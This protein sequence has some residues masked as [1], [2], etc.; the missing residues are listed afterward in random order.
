MFVMNDDL[1]IYATRGDI[2]F[3]NV[4]AMD[5]NMSYKFQPGEIVRMSIYGKKEA[6]ECVMQKDFAVE[7]V[8][9]NVFI[10]LDEE[11]T[12][13]GE[14]ISKHKDYWYEIVLNP[15]TMPQT[16]IGYDE[17]GAKIFR[18]FPESA[19]I[20][21]TYQPSVED[22]PVVDSELDMTSPRP[23]A[24]QAIARA[25][26]TIL[27]TCERTNAAVA[28]N[29][30]TPEMFGAI[31]DG[32]ADDTEAIQA[33]LDSGARTVLL[34]KSYRIS[35]SLKI[36]SNTTVMFSGA[37]HCYQKADGGYYSA[38]VLEDVENVSLDNPRLVCSYEIEYEWSHGI[39]LNRTRN[40]SMYN[41]HCAGFADGVCVSYSISSESYNDNLYIDSIIADKCKRNGVT[42]ECCKDS[43]IGRI[44]GIEVGGFS[45]NTCL[46]IEHDK[47]GLSIENLVIDSVY[48]YKCNGGVQ[49]IL[50]GY[51]NINVNNVEIL[52]GNFYFTGSES[53]VTIDSMR[54]IYSDTIR[55]FQIMDNGAVAIK[56]K[57]SIRHLALEGNGISNDVHLVYV[58]CNSNTFIDVESVKIDGI[59]SKYLY[60][61]DDYTDTADYERHCRLF[62]VDGFGNKVAKRAS[63]KWLN[64]FSSKFEDE[65][66]SYSPVLLLNSELPKLRNTW[67]GAETV[68]EIANGGKIIIPDCS[69]FKPA[70]VLNTVGDRIR[71]VFANNTE[72]SRAFWNV[73]D[74]FLLSST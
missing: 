71:I 3:F 17:N 69:N 14:S 40:V 55:D 54:C 62:G 42:V 59:S 50:N 28:E 49:F 21:D 24:N 19:E 15:D 67:Q 56:T 57:L 16:I 12:K 73:K 9:E 43:Y 41:V 34:H 36:K 63:V 2:V 5:G 64:D 70:A 10:F 22:F 47:A 7:E 44:V 30:V 66:Y 51:G 68:F 13:I 18:L 6:D 39:L 31:G 11:D 45:P 53:K 26:T 48:S 58:K 20:E 37:I 8:T 65:A 74:C 61:I 32:V 1:S 27:D 25:V 23:V 60:Y 72:S 29:F 38:V 4:S 52:D 46:D 33:A 35:D